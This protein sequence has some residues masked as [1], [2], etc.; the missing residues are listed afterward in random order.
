M[1]QKLCPATLSLGRL[2]PRPASGAPPQQRGCKCQQESNSGIAAIHPSSRLTAGHG[3]QCF[4]KEGAP[5]QCQYPRKNRAVV[6]TS[7]HDARNHRGVKSAMNDTN[8]KSISPPRSW[9]RDGLPVRR[10]KQ[11]NPGRCA[12]IRHHR[13]GRPF[14][15]KRPCPSGAASF[16]ETGPCRSSF[17]PI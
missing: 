5:P 14:D 13:I 6:Q 2:P 17:L 7:D 11:M 3:P 15:W 10:L 1:G 16:D 4:A 12:Y 9:Q 8:R